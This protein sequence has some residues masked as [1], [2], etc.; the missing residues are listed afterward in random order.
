MTAFFK[1]LVMYS[2]TKTDAPLDSVYCSS[3][4]DL[5]SVI[6][7]FKNLHPTLAFEVIIPAEICKMNKDYTHPS[8]LVFTKARINKPLRRWSSVFEKH[9]M[10]AGCIQGTGCVIART[11]C[12][13]QGDSF[14]HIIILPG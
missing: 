14:I 11:M 7:N 12:T 13:P 2:K 8:Q 5:D 10:H 3:K 1:Y 6:L 4:T 9:F